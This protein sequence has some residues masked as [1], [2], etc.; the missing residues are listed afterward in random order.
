[1]AEAARKTNGAL[2]TA[3]EAKGLAINQQSIVDV[4]GSKI[5]S[6]LMSGELALPKN[7]SI[8]NAM[9]FA[10]LALQD[11]KDKENRPALEV[12]T[13]DSIVNSLLSMVVQGLNVGK[14]QGY[15]IA[16]GVKLAFQRSYFGTMAITKMVEPRIDDFAFMVV[17]QGDKFKYGIHQGKKM[18]TDHEQEL[19]NVQKDK[20]RAA[21]C[22]AL[23]HEGKVF[24]T[25]IMTLAEIH[26][27][28]KQS[29]QNPFDDKGHLRPGTTH[30]KFTADMCLRTV[31]NKCC[32]PIINTSTDSQLL[33]DIIKKTEDLA[34]RAEV[35]AE[36]EEQANKGAVIDIT[37]KLDGGGAQQEAAEEALVDTYNKRLKEAKDFA[38]LN[39]AL[40]DAKADAGLTL[41]ERRDLSDLYQTEA[42]RLKQKTQAEPAQ[43][44]Q[45]PEDKKEEEKQEETKEEPTRQAERKP[46]F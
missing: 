26:Q 42:K 10:W 17:Y 9:K 7:Y 3:E 18:V 22:M 21:Y 5:N 15:F 12:C 32:K 16:Y 25:E 34:D 27:S 39:A 43:A 40:S 2:M 41:E 44:E 37:P 23:D 19:D 1:M 45:P 8:E 13:K 35:E 36:I 30:Y 33:L 24:R 46:G 14:N 28:W 11:V 4:V 20:I 6:F 38:E 29:K 31:I